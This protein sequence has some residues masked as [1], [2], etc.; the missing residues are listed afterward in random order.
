MTDFDLEPSTTPATFAALLQAEIQAYEEK[1]R[2]LAPP[3][4]ARERG[5]MDLYVALVGCRRR[6]LAA[7]RDGAPEAWLDYPDPLDQATAAP[8]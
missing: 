6:M 5:L 7:L 2:A 3:R 4:T 1:A 8:A